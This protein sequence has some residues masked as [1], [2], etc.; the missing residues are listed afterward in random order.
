MPVTLCSIGF[1]RTPATASI[2]VATTETLILPSRLSSN[3]E[4]KMMLALSSTSSRILFAASSTSKRVIS[5]P[6]V[7]LISTPLAPLI[8]VSSNSGFAM[9]ASAASIA[10]R[11]PSASP[12]PI[13]ALPISLITDLI[14][15]KSRFMRPGITIR[16]VTPRTPEYNTSSAIL[17]ASAKVV[18]S[19]A[20]LNKFWL[21]IISRVSTYC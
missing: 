3:V 20:T 10:R 4:P 18:F 1:V 13:I 2:P 21:G 19:F 8:E 6:A 16:S 12:V 7:I 9:A 14:S 5:L 15:A 11:S 17:N